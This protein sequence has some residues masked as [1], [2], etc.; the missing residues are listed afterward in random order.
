MSN[1]P[2]DFEADRLADKCRDIDQNA[3]RLEV[4]RGNTVDATDVIISNC[5]D[6]GDG[7]FVSPCEIQIELDGDDPIQSFSDQLT[8]LSKKA[9][10]ML[11]ADK[12]RALERQHEAT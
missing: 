11:E 9:L 3:R 10:A 7:E 5:L 12:K 2:M 6:C 8:A 4:F 1:D